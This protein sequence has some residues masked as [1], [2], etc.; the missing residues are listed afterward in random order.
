MKKTVFLVLIWS[1]CSIVQIALAV[2]IFLKWHTECGALVLCGSLV[3]DCK[4]IFWTAF[5]QK[6]KQWFDVH[7]ACG[8]FL[9]VFEIG[10]YTLYGFFLIFAKTRIAIFASS[11][12]LTII[13]F[14]N[15]YLHLKK[16]KSSIGQG[17]S[18]PRP[19]DGSLPPSPS[20]QDR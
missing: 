20:P 15:L 3:S 7:T 2:A 11:V 5:G 4:L 18:V 1:A 13:I 14:L 12:G 9:A 17:R 8:N 16:Q 10:F 6:S 19:E